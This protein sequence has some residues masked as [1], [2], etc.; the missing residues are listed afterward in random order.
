MPIPSPPAEGR[1]HQQAIAVP[2][3]ASR[4]PVEKRLAGID[5]PDHA[6]VIGENEKLAGALAARLDEAAH[7]ISQVNSPVPHLIWPPR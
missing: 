6:A 4:E 1:K 3:P 5:R 2:E 7:H